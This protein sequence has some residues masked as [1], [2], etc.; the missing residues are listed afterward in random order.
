MS[1]D[2][3]MIAENNHSLDLDACT[4]RRRGVFAG[5][6]LH[7]IQKQIMCGNELQIGADEMVCCHCGKLATLS[8]SGAPIFHGPHAPKPLL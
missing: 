1:G 3:R 4:E 6:C 5:H 2:L 8:V 7:A